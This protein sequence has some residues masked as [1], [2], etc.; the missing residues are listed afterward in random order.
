MTSLT[1]SPLMVGLIPAATGLSFFLLSLP[2][3]ALADILDKR[4]LLLF[5]QAWMALAALGIGCL[6]LAGVVGPWL[7]LGATF[8]LGI[9]AALAA[10]AWQAM[11][12]ELVPVKEVPVAVAL[13]GLGFN[14]SRAVGPALGGV[15]VATAGSATAFLVNAVSFLGLLG[16]LLRW[17]RAPRGSPLPAERLL[18]AMRAGVRYARHAPALRA[19]LVRSGLFILCGS[20]LW[21][22]L[23]L[24][25]R[26]RLGLDSARYG[27]LLAAF[28][29]GAIGSAAGL[30]RIRKRAPPEA[31]ALGAGVLLAL[32][33]AALAFVRSMASALIVLGVA[34]VPWLALMTSF[35]VAAQSAV[36]SWVR[37]R[38][39]S[40]YGLVFFGGMAGG[41]AIWGAVA[42][43]TSI[44]VSLVCAA[45]ALLA[46]VA[47]SSRWS[48][49]TFEPGALL[50]SRHWPTPLVAGSVEDER[51]PVLVTVEYRADPARAPE[52]EAAMRAVGRLRRRDGAVSWALFS[53]AAEP[54]RYLETFLV[55]SWAEHL[56][57]HERSTMAD[58]PLEERV[59]SYLPGGMPRVTHYLSAER[60]R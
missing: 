47:V 35:N 15:V 53:D 24:L 13:G 60:G 51:G 38:A 19:V 41:S 16:A 49:P 46:T 48:L 55:E 32:A 31:I 43:R 27:L 57:Q 18:A 23:P 26:Q 29:A 2:A 30:P 34:G 3:G 10:P 7:L 9:G 17:R 50:P 54:G 20:A 5:A 14:L 39:L 36:P 8:V 40:F 44:Q 22:T 56:R 4:R 37:A 42:E 52:F 12:P 1:P 45:A 6:A 28:G 21:A 11:V 33:L 58:R 25:A 59:R